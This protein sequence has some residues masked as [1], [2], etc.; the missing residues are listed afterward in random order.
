MDLEQLTR[1]AASIAS[2][3]VGQ[4]YSQTLGKLAPDTCQE[5]A[6]NSVAIAMAIE[7]AGRETLTRKA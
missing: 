3:M 2:G 6:E 4:K 1:A 7:K 5:I